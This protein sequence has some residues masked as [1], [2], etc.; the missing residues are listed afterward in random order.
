[1]E[2]KKKSRIDGDLS[3]FI[4]LSLLKEGPLSVKELQERTALQTMDF[5][6]RYRERRRERKRSHPDVEETCDGLVCKKW[7]NVTDQGKY[8]LTPDGKARAEETA[9]AMERGAAILQNQLL[10][11]TATAR[12]T[13]AGYVFLSVVKLL[14][15]FFSGSVGLIADGAD[16][17]VDTSASSIV[18][19]GIKFKKEI[20]GTITIIG[21]MFVTAVIL[22]YDS[23]ASVIENIQGVF[24][25][26]TMPYVVIIIELLA[27]VTM[28]TLSLYQRF[29]GKRSQ[30]L[31]LISQSIDSKNSVYSSAA[32]IVGAVF[33]IFGVY[34][35]DAIVGGFIAVRICLD[36]FDLSK[37]IM[38]TLRGQKPEFSKF[39]L[40]FEKQIGERR[41]DTFRNWIMYS[42]HE[43]KLTT[44]QEI[45]ASL[46]TA[47]RPS[48]MPQV[49]TE[50]TVGKDFAFESNFM[51]IVKPLLDEGYMV[52]NEGVFNLTDRGKAYLKGK[53]GSMRY[54]QT[55]L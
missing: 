52:E 26:M 55:E 13:T 47:F 29:V 40:P 2:K 10:S 27:M 24:L 31:A 12:N 49:F 35:V 48:Y 43:D 6:E 50:F 8:E 7:L 38:A 23:A 42:V 41:M 19:F 33:S 54:K 14:A 18:W 21:L 53:I 4:L 32:V 20:L 15:G 28:F 11:P 5:R 22:F 34:W 17:T 45:V 25:P 9:K 30:S 1:M 16:T 51:S 37:D 36:G 3:E 46:E 39:K 44:K